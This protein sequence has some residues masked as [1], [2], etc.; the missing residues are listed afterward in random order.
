MTGNPPFYSFSLF[1]T[2]SITFFINKP[3]YLKDLTVLLTSSI[4]SFEI[5]NVAMP[6]PEKTSFE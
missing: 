4:S 3:D 6:E 5:I 1:L 2:I